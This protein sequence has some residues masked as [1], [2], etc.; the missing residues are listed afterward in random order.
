VNEC[1]RDLTVAIIEIMA[2]QATIVITTRNRKEDL[3]RAIQSC[4]EQDADIE[5]LVFDDASTDGT[6]EMVQREFPNIRLLCTEERVGYIALRNRGFQIAN[7]EIVFSIDDDARFTDPSTVREAL[8]AFAEDTALGALA[9][10]YTEPNRTAMQGY[11]CEVPSGNRLRN[12]IGCAHAIR[13]NAA[14]NLGGYREYFVHQGEE[15]D[16]SIRMLHAGYSVR[17]LNSPPIIH[18]P[19]SIRDNSRMNYFGYRN[20]FLFD[21]LNVPL[22]SLLYRL[23][24]DVV[25]LIKHRLTLFNMP[26]NLMNTFRSLAACVWFV[27]RRAPVS[28]E[29]Y[30]LYKSLPTHGAVDPRVL[31][32]PTAEVGES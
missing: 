23:P 24:L 10:R 5:V 22:P 18:E 32:R 30:R 19:S 20:T 28:R 27:P 4:L 9:L 17:Y 8:Q 6:S 7:G 14:K 11:M 3:R 12:Y 31:R 16:L 26:W 1:R 25:L 13:V 21:I 2:P 29:T 15:R